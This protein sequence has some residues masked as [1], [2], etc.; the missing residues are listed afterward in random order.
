[1]MM[2]TVTVTGARI[3]H[4]VAVVPPRELIIRVVLGPL[5]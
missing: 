3:I 1:M 2:M 5:D 4:I